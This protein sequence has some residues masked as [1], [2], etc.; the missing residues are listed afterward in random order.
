MPCIGGEMQ[1]RDPIFI[2]CIGVGS[3]RE[4]F[5]YDGCVSVLGGEMQRRDP[6][7]IVCIGVDSARKQVFDGVYVT[8]LGCIQESPLLFI[9]DD[10][11]RKLYATNVFFIPRRYIN[12]SAS[13]VLLLLLLSV[14]C[15]WNIWQNILC[16]SCSSLND[17]LLV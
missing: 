4:Q 1:R 16:I 13:F 14:P 6:I 2:L 12:K 3:V 10:H 9:H 15:I 7:C 8:A 11:Y 5:V 17:S